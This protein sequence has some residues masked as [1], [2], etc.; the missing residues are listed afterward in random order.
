MKSIFRDGC[1]KKKIYGIKERV[2]MQKESKEFL[3]QLLSQCGPSGFEEKAQDVWTERTRAYADDVRR[4]VHGN[5]I[6]SLNEGAGL[7]VMLAGHCDEIGFIISH[8][9]KEGFLHV[10]AIGG[11]DPGVL[12]GSQVKVQTEKGWID[13]VIGKKA[14]HLMETEERNK[15][16][17][18]KDLWVDIGAKDRKDA[19]KVVRVGDP[20][21]FAPNFV[22]LRNGIFSS[23]GC[24]DKVGAFVVSEVM[25]I[26]NQRKSEL[27]VSVYSVATVQE[28]VGLRGATT[29]A[30]GIDPDVGIAVDV[31]FASD[32]PGIDKRLVGEVSLGKGPILHAG[33]QINRVLGKMMIDSAKKKKIS[34]QYTSLGRPGGTDTS[35]IQL[36]RSGVATALVGIP[37]RYMHTMVE[38]CSFNDVLNAAELIAET[39]LTMTPKT[40][41]IP[42]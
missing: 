25:K 10:I 16:V 26:L 13:G 4:D 12:P 27:T 18:L 24:D 39:I 22:E 8:I 7:K 32:T 38:T 15:V 1:G 29:S 2:F 31:G 42:R 33:P 11:I 35:A 40:N 28:E 37:N 3:V 17:Q 20:V 6:A 5:A 23:K 19:E 34:Y 9:S 14:I 30:F 36:T 21:S 41:F